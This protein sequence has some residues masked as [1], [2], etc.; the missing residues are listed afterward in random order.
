[1]PARHCVSLCYFIAWICCVHR[2]F[3]DVQVFWRVTLN[4]TVT[5][6]QKEELNLTDELRFVAGVTTCPVGQTRCFIHLE[7]NPEKVSATNCSPFLQNYSSQSIDIETCILCGNYIQVKCQN[8]F[9]ILDVKFVPSSIFV[10]SIFY[11]FVSCHF[12]GT[13]GLAIRYVSTILV[14]LTDSN[15]LLLCSFRIHKHFLFFF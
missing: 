10:K 13:L 2:A 11:V 12:Q 9:Q 7:L 1:M 15:Y 14:S 3:E 5:I 6:L 8:L 4:Q